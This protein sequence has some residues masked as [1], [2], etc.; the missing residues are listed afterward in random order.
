MSK[1]L[2]K[3]KT[4][5]IIMKKTT[6]LLSASLIVAFAT[7]M[8]ASADFDWNHERWDFKKW[9][10]ERMD[11]SHWKHDFQRWKFHKRWEFKRMSAEERIEKINADKNLT[12]EEKTERIER[13]KKHEEFKNMTTD[14][15]ISA[16]NSDEN[17]TDEEKAERVS[18]IQEMEER[19][20]KIESLIQNASDE[21]KAI[22]EKRKAWEEISDDEKEV[23]K[24]FFEKNWIEKPKRW[25]RHEKKWWKNMDWKKDSWKFF[26]KSKKEKRERMTSEEVI[27]KIN[28]DENLTDEEKAER[29]KKVNEREE[30]MAQK[31]AERVETLNTIKESVENNS[32][33]S[34]EKKSD[35]L[36][37]ITN[38]LSRFFN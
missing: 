29:I 4:N 34:D 8:F 18:K 11:F 31:K 28:A 23:M 38:I 19:K 10:A 37:R 5:L 21:V 3:I 30:K 35:I 17:L 25:D 2:T 22:H 12:D 26:D 14:E 6:Q 1:G 9:M 32:N 16:V 20:S 33:L 15:K 13:V 7:P 24:E 27:E 36:E